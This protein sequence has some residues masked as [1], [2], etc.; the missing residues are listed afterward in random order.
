MTESAEGLADLFLFPFSWIEYP[1]RVIVAA[2]AGVIVTRIG[3]RWVVPTVGRAIRAFGPIAS[4]RI[5]SLLMLP[6]WVLTDWFIRA[7]RRIPVGLRRYGAAVEDLTDLFVHGSKVVGGA[8]VT[9]R[10]AGRSA[11]VG[12]VA[13][14][15][16]LLNVPGTDEGRQKDD[17]PIVHWWGEFSA[18]FEEPEEPKGKR[19]GDEARNGVEQEGK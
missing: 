18:L 19:S 1:L 7:S 14:V 13:I 16:I 8:L 6:E 2:V 5:C 4:R 12:L 11:A 15:I 10:S 3:L 9:V 17:V